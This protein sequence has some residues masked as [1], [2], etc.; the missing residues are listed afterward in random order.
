MSL[1]DDTVVRL[2][3]D[4]A[5]TVATSDE[6]LQSLR[7]LARQG[8]S[9]EIDC[10]ALTAVDLSFIQLLLSGYRSV[11]AAGQTFRVRARTGGPL[12]IALASGGFHDMPDVNAS[13]AFSA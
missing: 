8:Q 3:L 11:S 12:E 13:I 10:T 9:I 4:G 1:P 6:T 7:D 5:R 2:V